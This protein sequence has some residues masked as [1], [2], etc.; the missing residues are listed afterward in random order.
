MRKA[1]E[2]VDS[3]G[4]TPMRRI[5]MTQRQLAA[6]C[7]MQDSHIARIEAGHYSVGLDTL[8]VI[9]DALGK[10]LEFVDKT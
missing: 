9:G 2:W 7:S 1:V 10:R 4:D 3:S 6:L 8:T 5:G